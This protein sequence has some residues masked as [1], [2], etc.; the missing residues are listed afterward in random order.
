MSDS[1]K[2]NIKK[3]E[4][5]VS[6]WNYMRYSI[7]SETLFKEKTASSSYP[8]LITEY[9]FEMVDDRLP[10]TGR[11]S[12]EEPTWCSHSNTDAPNL[13]RYNNK[14]LVS[15]ELLRNIGIHTSNYE[16][17]RF[18]PSKTEAGWTKRDFFVVGPLLIHA[19][20]KFEANRNADYDKYRAE[21][22]REFGQILLVLS[23]QNI[24]IDEED[25]DF[26]PK[27]SKSLEERT[28]E[29]L[30]GFQPKLR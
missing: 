9:K 18:G 25:N 19:L 11:V 28:R 22:I 7:S 20:Q 17:V 21:E 5:N 30:Q 12:S 6:N 16:V 8:E 24:D 1:I 26:I 29:A 23:T 4:I 3:R 27:E 10:E 13:V 2:I 14:L 15:K